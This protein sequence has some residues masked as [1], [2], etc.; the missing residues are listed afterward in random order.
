MT[1]YYKLPAA[2][3]MAQEHG[4]T[5]SDEN[6]KPLFTTGY[7]AQDVIHYVRDPEQFSVKNGDILI[8]T[9]HLIYQASVLY[10]KIYTG[11]PSDP[12]MLPE[13]YMSVTEVS[14]QP[15]STSGPAVTQLTGAQIWQRN[16]KAFIWPLST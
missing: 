8:T 11:S 4:I 3:Y 10:K 9:D 6:G 14:Y 7:N 15:L 13:R 1:L 5:F 16:G 12:V 2:T